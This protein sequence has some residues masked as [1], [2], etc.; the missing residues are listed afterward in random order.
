MKNLSDSNINANSDKELES[1]LHAAR[2]S[3]HKRINSLRQSLKTS[4]SEVHN[5]ELLITLKEDPATEAFVPLRIKEL[6]EDRAIKEMIEGL[7]KE[8]SS[9]LTEIQ[10]LKSDKSKLETSL[11]RQQENLDIERGKLIDLEAERRQLKENL[12]NTQSILEEHKEIL[13]Q[14]SSEL[15]DVLMQSKFES[16]KFIHTLENNEKENFRQRSELEILRQQMERDFEFRNDLKNQLKESRNNEAQ[17]QES[18]RKWKE[19]CQ[20]NE[21][22]NNELKDKLKD[23]EIEI[24]KLAGEIENLNE[25]KNLLAKD[26][27][28]YRKIAEDTKISLQNDWKKEIETLSKQNHDKEKKLKSALKKE[29][30]HRGILE[31]K[32]NELRLSFEHLQAQCFSDRERFEM[33]IKEVETYYE[34]QINSIHEDY[35]LKLKEMKDKHDKEISDLN[36]SSQNRLDKKQKEFESHVSVLKSEYEDQIQD[37]EYKLAQH[38]N[39]LENDYMPK[40][41]HSDLITEKS[42]EQKSQFQRDLQSQETSLRNEHRK[43]IKRLNQQHDNMVQALKAKLAQTE[44]EKMEELRNKLNL[45]SLLEIETSKCA[46]FREKLIKLEERL[47]ELEELKQENLRT[48]EKNSEN[49]RKI[50]AELNLSQNIKDD[51]E[52]RYKELLDKNSYLEKIAQDKDTSMKK[53]IDLEKSQHLDRSQGF[54]EEVTR[55]EESVEKQKDEI[56]YLKQTIYSLEKDKKEAA[57]TMQKLI[58]KNQFEILGLKDSYREQLHSASEN[59]ETLK[60][61][62]KQSEKQV[63]SVKNDLAKSQENERNFKAEIEDFHEDLQKSIARIKEFEINENHLTEE[64]ERLSQSLI[65]SKIKQQ[66]LNNKWKRFI[67]KL[68]ERYIQEIMAMQK[69]TFDNLAEFKKYFNSTISELVKGLNSKASFSIGKLIEKLE[70]SENRANALQKELSEINALKE[71][72]IERNMQERNMEKEEF[73]AKFSQLLRE[74]EIKDEKI[75]Y[76]EVSIEDS[77]YKNKQLEK[78]KSELRLLILKKEN[79]LSETYNNSL[80]EKSYIEKNLSQQQQKAKFYLEEKYKETLSKLIAQI[81]SLEESTQ[82]QFNEYINEI[83]LLKDVHKEEIEEVKSN[84]SEQIKQNNSLILQAKGSIEW[85]KNQL[86]IVE[87]DLQKQTNKFKE[88]TVNYD[89]EIAT[90]MQDLKNEQ[91]AKRDLKAETGKEIENLVRENRQ[92]KLELER[93][94]IN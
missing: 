44:N 27:E 3:Y 17:L 55:L 64:N 72:N 89:K 15:Q 8:L 13:D 90:V 21:I 2:E 22:M 39:M 83:S 79:E 68:K 49:L 69:E 4:Y 63:I 87:S 62:L 29:K 82:N 35:E 66:K 19:R 51:L 94:K 54:D 60:I 45:Q 73:K 78:D 11:E 70:K 52:I 75:K 61:Q 38:K 85:Y 31:E 46:A 1:I 93:V 14:K 43:E 40:K 50:K 34:Q 56:A 26:F 23:A 12:A 30:D 74:T 48:S 80:F 47:T 77:I 57:I 6:N 86:S 7:K 41:S 10:L 18:S 25:E 53:Y 84:A 32:F 5:D 92:L 58:E 67:Y 81:R 91:K 37:F 20:E 36:L 71:E 88:E 42:I 16:E 33:K 24:N 59:I 65:K 9:C 28:D 76:L